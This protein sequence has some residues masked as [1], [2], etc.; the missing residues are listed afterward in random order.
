MFPPQ[1]TTTV[2]V[3]PPSTSTSLLPVSLSFLICSSYLR[4]SLSARSHSSRPATAQVQL[5][6]V[7]PLHQLRQETVLARQLTLIMVLCATCHVSSIDRHCTNTPRTCYQCCTSHADIHTCP[8]HYRQMGISDAAARLAS[9]KVH[10]SIAED[11]E[12]TAPSTP[13]RVHSAPPGESDLPDVVALPP[14]LCGAG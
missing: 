11:I 1:I 3:C 8:L 2:H 10:P 12:K 13:A 14:A 5:L 4:R 9:G 6:I 7:V